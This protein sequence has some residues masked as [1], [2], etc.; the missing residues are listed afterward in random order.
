MC[1]RSRKNNNLDVCGVFVVAVVG[2]FFLFAFKVNCI[3]RVW[4]HCDVCCVFLIPAL[5]VY[6]Y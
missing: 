6:V 5:Q 1:M 3:L 4:L 2:G